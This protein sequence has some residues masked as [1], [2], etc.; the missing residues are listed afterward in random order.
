MFK[1]HRGACLQIA[2]LVLISLA[3]EDL[4]RQT[5][6]ICNQS[7]QQT[8]CLILNDTQ[9]SL[10]HKNAINPEATSPFFS[11]DVLFAS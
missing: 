8:V 3:S 1:N 6:P 7:V 5:K 9:K 4:F 10:K 2:P 11:G